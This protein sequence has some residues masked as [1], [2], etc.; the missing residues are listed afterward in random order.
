MN[1][2]QQK[3]ADEINQMAAEDQKYRQAKPSEIKNWD[4]I[5]QIDQRNL[6]RIKEIVSQYGCITISEF[7]EKNNQIT[8][9][10]RDPE[11]YKTIT[12]KFYLADSHYH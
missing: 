9:A 5:N 3:I 11:F 12:N 8:Y 2:Q 1:P 4:E 7:D 6:A 10:K